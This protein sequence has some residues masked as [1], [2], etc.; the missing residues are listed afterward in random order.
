MTIGGR[1]S[2]ATG[3]ALLL[4]L[5]AG[6]ARSDPARLL[7][8]AEDADQRLSYRGV[9]VV[10]TTRGE[11]SIER[12]V[13]VSHLAPDR[14]RVEY[15]EPD[16]GNILLESGSGRWYY[17]A[18]WNRWR[19]IEYRPSRSRMD[20]LLQNYR[21][22]S[23]GS[24][25]V[26]GRRVVQLSIEPRY[27]GNPQKR[28]WIDPGCRMVLREEVLDHEGHVIVSSAFEQF[29]LVRDPR[30]LPASLFIP[31]AVPSTSERSADLPFAPLL[32]RYVPPGYRE[33]QRSGLRRGPGA[34]LFLRYTDGL[35]TISLVEFR[36]QATP[37]PGQHDGPHKRG[38]H[39]WGMGAWG[40]AKRLTRRIGD[41]DCHVMGETDPEEL[42]K[43]LDSVPGTAS[44][45]DPGTSSSG[46]RLSQ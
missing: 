17:A 4:V 34:G 2:A 41:L 15:L 8:A 14:T 6:I 32:P 7:Q 21:V 40:H 19:P 5:A 18:R 25:R 29:E 3:A 24:D 11:S 12:R 30:E 26:A 20:L 33:V 13:R 28:V 44:S 31:P 23:L 43:M 10:R 37:P 42:R 1:H 45:V 46:R 27:P 39:G 9:R 16:G 38:R 22:H 35:G 36:H